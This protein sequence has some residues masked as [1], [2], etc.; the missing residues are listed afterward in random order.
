MRSA[1]VSS[2]VSIVTRGIFQAETG[3]VAFCYRAVRGG[4]QQVVVAELIHAVVVSIN[5]RKKPD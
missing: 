2:V 3:L 5:E 4:I 1:G